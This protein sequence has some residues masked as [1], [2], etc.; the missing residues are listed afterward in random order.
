MTTVS[1]DHNN[2]QNNEMILRDQLIKYCKQNF[3][4]MNIYY[5]YS[6]DIYF[7]NPGPFINFFP[8]LANASSI[9]FFF[10]A[11]NSSFS[12]RAFSS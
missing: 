4:L 6:S 7:N 12:I 2:Q 8:L 3:F 9:L 5:E 10:A 1:T 11:S